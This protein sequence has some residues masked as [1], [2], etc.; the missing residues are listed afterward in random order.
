MALKVLMLRKKI[1][2]AQ[3]KLEALR[4]K[5]DDF[6]KREKELEDS[7]PEAET[8]EEKATVEEEVG[9]FES[10]KAEHDKEKADVE[11][12]IAD[13]EAELK[14]T[15]EANEQPPA[16]APAE[17]GEQRKE[18]HIMNRITRYKDM[19][20]QERS[21]FVQRNEIQEFLKRVRTFIAERRSVN[22]ADLAIPTDVLELL[23]PE[24]AEAS[25][26]YNL[27]NLEQR[28]G[29]SRLPVEGTIPEGI[30]MEAC[31]ALNELDI[32]FNM[33]EMD[34]FKVGGFFVI[35][36]ASEKD[37]DID[38][39]AEIIRALKVAI[40]KG[41][42]KAIIF[43]TGIKMPLGIATRLAQTSQP[44]DWDADRGAWTDLHESNIKTLNIGSESGTTFFASLINTLGIASPKYSLDKKLTWV[45][46]HKTHIDIMSKALAFNA[47]AALVAGMKDEMPVIGGKIV[48]MD[49]DQMQDYEIIG[50]YMKVYKLVEREGAAIATSEHVRFIQG[51]LVAGGY[52]RYDGDPVIGEAFVIVNYNNT[53]P[54]TSATFPTDY[55]NSDIGFL[56]VTAA[57]GTAAG[58]TV[59]TVTGTELSGTTLAYKL[60]NIAVENGKKVRGFTALTSGTTQITAAAG[61]PITVVELNGEG[62]AIKV[63]R[64]AS[65]PKSA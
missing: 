24:V 44:E 5:D 52:A 33:V 7:I 28:R 21:A 59:L 2:D 35:C 26:L 34:G 14:A 61:D 37:S 9:K 38:L 41:L 29:K 20:M 15:E 54:E 42:D 10:E 1:A 47:A 46:N 13:L 18:V 48:E 12:T 25:Q 45:M 58:D 31:G 16:P 60:G 19:T 57:A 39:M 56:G 30:W 6:A 3:K 63:G 4:S 65:I 64:V 27:V 55:A 8:D 36:K 51:Q 50:G 22:G 62:R 53:A 40:A 32:E 43:G 49:D 23:R 17:E 11:K